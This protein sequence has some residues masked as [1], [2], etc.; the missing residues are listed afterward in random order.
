MTSAAKM[1]YSEQIP[2]FKEVT[3]QIKELVK[4]RNQILQDMIPDVK[5]AIL[6]KMDWKELKF[7]RMDYNF[8]SIMVEVENPKEQE[9][10]RYVFEV[11]PLQHDEFKVVLQ[12]RE[13]YKY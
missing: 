13:E 4:Q 2:K 3:A 7:N 5:K 6:S 12:F 9:W 1:N 10:H 11:V 8:G